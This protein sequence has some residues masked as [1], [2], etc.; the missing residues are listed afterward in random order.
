MKKRTVLFV[1]AAATAAL[2]AC[3]CCGV[4][5][6][7][8]GGNG[9]AVRLDAQLGS[10]DPAKLVALQLS[11][12]EMV[13]SYQRAQA[14]TG[15]ALGAH[16]TDMTAE[17]W[18]ALYAEAVGTW[19][20]TAERADAFAALAERVPEREEPSASLVR[21]Q[22]SALA[23][24]LGPETAHA[25][26]AEPFPL[27][28]EQYRMVRD[29]SVSLDRTETREALAQLAERAPVV[30]AY[31][32]APSGSKLKQAAVYV[33]GDAR[34][35]QEILTS[36]YG[37]LKATFDDDAAR[38]EIAWRVATAIETGS[39][40]AL[41][42]GD[43]ATGGGK[44]ALTKSVS[45]NLL[46]RLGNPK[47]L[48]RTAR[49]QLREKTFTTV[50]GHTDMVVGLY[51]R[52]LVIATGDDAAAFSLTGDAASSLS[53]LLGLKSLRGEKG[54]INN[55]ADMAKSPGGWKTAYG[56]GSLSGSLSQKGLNVLSA[57]LGADSASIETYVAAFAEAPDDAD[58][59][60]LALRS[61]EPS[62]ESIMA[63]RGEFDSRYA[64]ALGAVW[65]SPNDFG[66]R[67]TLQASE[68]SAPQAP[69]KPPASSELTDGEIREGYVMWAENA[70]AALY[71]FAETTGNSTAVGRMR[72]EVTPLPDGS[73][74]VVI[75]DDAKVW[76]DQ[77]RADVLDFPYAKWEAWSR[78]QDPEKYRAW[79]AAGQPDMGVFSQG[80]DN[81][82][83]L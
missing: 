7:F 54:V 76:S 32:A 71:A 36:N 28:I 41:F 25:Q 10:D 39:D 31:E 43:L 19:A 24:L 11:L 8:F 22:A 42:V 56:W 68:P 34:K 51:N 48:A 30:L 66:V 6:L 65:S 47:L 78:R 64:E 44:V 13:W 50:V 23:A 26:E 59:T 72:G 79:C 5:F 62:L 63:M 82:Q 14:L 17:E 20:Y 55:L 21:P 2:L 53:M 73:F 29:D 60:E 3:S 46:T 83:D 80:R 27:D 35:A 45:K 61:A 38:A 67:F 12:E 18:D 58:V 70:I 37:D 77:T 75:R 57:D 69:S 33:G 40:V 74:R 9:D 49:E 1:V 15:I 4:G 81:M 52:G 16:S